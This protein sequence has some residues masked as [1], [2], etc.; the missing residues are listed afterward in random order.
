M[1]KA[2]STSTTEESAEDF[3]PLPPSEPFN[4]AQDQP[5]E[6]FGAVVQVNSQM[7]KGMVLAHLLMRNKGEV[8]EASV[9]VGAIAKTL[10]ITT[11]EVNQAL[12]DLV[13]EKR[14]EMLAINKAIFRVERVHVPS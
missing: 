3:D 2:N 10:G 7:I 14:V 5:L 12:L 1:S 8:F 4:S 11:F 6:V 9:D 13:A